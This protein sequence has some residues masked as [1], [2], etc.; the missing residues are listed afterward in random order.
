MEEDGRNPKPSAS[1]EKRML[2]FGTK[3][4]FSSKL[5]TKNQENIVREWE[6]GILPVLNPHITPT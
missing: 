5:R 3:M 6:P 1:L 4:A 2:T